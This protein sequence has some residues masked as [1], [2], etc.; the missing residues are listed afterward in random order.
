MTMK[1]YLGTTVAGLLLAT[2]AFGETTATAWTDLNLRAGP[3]PMYEITTVIPATETVVVRGCLDASNWCEVQY[4]EVS[5]WA[6]GDYLTA[7]ID[8][9]AVPIYENREL[10]AIETVT[11]SET[12]A[13]TAAG[14]VT[15][16][17]AGAM[18]AGPIGALVGA[19]IGLGAGAIAEPAESVTTY[20][21]SNPVDPVFLDGEI[22]VGAGIP[23]TVTLAE[24]PDSE[25][26]YTYV[27][28]LPVL[29]SREDRRIVYIVR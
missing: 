7:M 22:V 1:V 16:A 13:T 29:V 26:H 20:V 10:I 4:A 14:G 23:D 17:V 27:N 2:S 6:Y 3:G 5:G 19:A 18:V 9:V 28:G 21:M 8:S 24:V 12:G 25:Y 15:G 11:Y